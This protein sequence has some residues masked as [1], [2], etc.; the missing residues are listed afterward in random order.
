MFT[1]TCTSTGG[2]ATTV[3]W[4]VDSSPVPDDGNYIFSQTVVNPVAGK[5]SNTLSVTGIKPGNYQCNVRNAGGNDASPIY[6]GT[7]KPINV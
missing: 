1:L 3:T 2:P 7:G 4:T 5:Y 6:E